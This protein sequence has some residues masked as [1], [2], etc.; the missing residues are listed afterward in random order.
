MVREDRLWVL[1]GGAVAGVVHGFLPNKSNS[2]KIGRVHGGRP[3]IMKDQEALALEERF[4]VIVLASCLG[5]AV[6]L[7]GATK[8]EDLKRGIPKLYLTAVVYGDFRRDLDLELL[9]DLLQKNGVI[10]NDRA[11]RR[12]AYD[13][14]LDQENP[15][16]LFEVGL[17]RGV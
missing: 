11:I 6:P 15:R 10:N 17:L 4:A 16:V 7:V 12:K 8:V 13:W 3:I 2:R 9:P 14:E 5:Q 1:E